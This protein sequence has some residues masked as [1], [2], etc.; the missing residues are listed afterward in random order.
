MDLTCSATSSTLSIMA[1][2]PATPHA[3][4][5]E[6]IMNEE[7]YL[8][9]RGTV[10]I[11]HSCVVT[12]EKTFWNFTALEIQFQLLVNLRLVVGRMMFWNWTQIKLE[13][14][15]IWF[16]NHDNSSMWA[17]HKWRLRRQMDMTRPLVASSGRKC[18]F[19]VNSWRAF[20]C[21]SMWFPRINP[22]LTHH[23]CPCW[24]AIAI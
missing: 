22:H 2:M 21:V 24:D 13:N 11:R 9:G 8:Y 14:H 1:S 19:M 15:D 7:K 3:K 5:H 12:K 20:V 23:E 17:P 10:I 16:E 4:Q 18:R 6:A